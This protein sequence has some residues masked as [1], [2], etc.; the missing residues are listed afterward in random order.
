MIRIGFVAC[1]ETMPG[2][3]GERR[4]DA[5]EHDLQ[6]AAIRPA[7]AAAG[8][9][10]VELE[11]RAPLADFN[12]IELVMLGSSW[13][14]QDHPAE[15]LAK[16]KA[17]DRAGIVVCNSP[18]LVEWNMDKKYLQDIAKGGA[19]IIPTL[20][21]DNPDRAEIV[22][23]F[24]HFD[25]DR[26][27]VKRQVGA[28][29]MGQHLFTKTDL[30]AD[31]WRMG[32]KAMIQPFLP[33]IKQEGELSFVF[34]DGEFSHA[35]RKMAAAGEYRIQSLYG[36]REEVFEPN[37]ADIDTAHKV[38]A[39]MPGEAP[40]YARIDMVRARTDSNDGALVLMEAEAVEPYLY[41][42]Q[43]PH[44]GKRLADAIV[45]RLN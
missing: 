42:E 10:L 33:A 34:I 26:L 7:F 45:R 1:P 43:G 36:G 24:E 18:A 3:S 28:G 4:G 27:V 11:W 19:S 17:L 8:L 14:Y 44:L 29:G 38:V 15:F 9:D 5:F 40:L 39:S 12:G 37:E 32:H 23:A 16:L 22:A 21:T 6:V 30:P 25:C 35:I 31:D 20:W 2:G 41:P 13:D